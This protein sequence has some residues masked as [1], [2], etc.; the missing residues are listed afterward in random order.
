VNLKIIE[1][2]PKTESRELSVMQ[3]AV[4]P[5]EKPFPKGIWMEENIR[6]WW[7]VI[8]EEKV[9]IVSIEKDSAPG[10]TYEADSEAGPGSI[11]LIL[12]GL[13]PEWRGKRLGTVAMAFLKAEALWMVG[14][15]RIV[16]NLRSSNHT[17]I[18]LHVSG[19]F[20]CIGSKPNYY[21]SPTCDSPVFELKL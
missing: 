12:I 2:D 15:N 10:S 21:S 16:S 17:S 11:Y 5:D 7:I 13:L 14:Y 9:G 3:V 19:G 18:N 6:A 1:A 4:L 8:N 20:E